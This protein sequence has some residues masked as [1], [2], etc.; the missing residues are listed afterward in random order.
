MEKSFGIKKKI[1]KKI[2]AP[3]ELKLPKIATVQKGL[4]VPNPPL[5]RFEEVSV[6]YPDG[7]VGLRNTS[8]RIPKGSLTTVLGPNGSGKT[9]LAKVCLKLLKPLK[10]KILIDNRD[11]SEIDTAE[12]PKLMGYAPQ[13]PLDMIF[14]DSVYEEVMFGVRNLKLDHPNE[15]VRDALN[16]IKIEGLSDKFPEILSLGQQRQLTLAICLAIRPK[17]LFLDEPELALDPNGI[18]SLTSILLE[19]KNETTIVILTHDVDTFVPLSDYV[20]LLSGGEVVSEGYPRDILTKEAAETIKLKVPELWDI[21]KISPEI[22][23]WE[24]L[25][26]KVVG[27]Y[28]D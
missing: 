7:T 12:V 26:R 1:R 20:I 17:L 11:L 14:C 18:E 21:W 4:K 6:V 25:S 24:E 15:R 16:K 19:L 13:D 22:K 10:G 8:L 2:L 23:S 27:L 9:T 5:V 3:N 28:D